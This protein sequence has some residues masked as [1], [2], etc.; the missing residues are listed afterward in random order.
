MHII[1][2][3][4]QKGGSGKTTVALAYAVAAT[5]QGQK[6]A[7]ID[8]DPQATAANW[9]DRREAET[10]WVV[11]TP[12]ARIKQAIATAEQQGVDLLLIDTPP[13]ASQ[14]AAEAARL[15]HLVLVP[16]RPHIF[17]IETLQTVRDMIRIAGDP[18]AVVVVNQAPIQGQ[19]AQQTIEAARAVGFDVAPVILYHRAAH[20]HATN[21]GQGPTEFD[22]TGK[23]AAET[24]HLYTYTRKLLN[25]LD[26]KQEK[27]RGQNKPA[28]ARA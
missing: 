12:A 17:D 27:T 8:V 18:P 7:V 9:T 22:P 19:A 21:I 15:S 3:M 4:G 2:V 25:N 28:R 1:T 11:A 14:L 10:P 23:A 5:Q 20:Q 6:V 24:L 26:L 16:C 13:H